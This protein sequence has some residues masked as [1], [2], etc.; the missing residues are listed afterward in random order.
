[1]IASK[2]KKCDEIRIIAP[3]RSINM[4]WVKS[5]VKPAKE[6]LE[7]MGFKVSFGKNVEQIDE[8]NY[9]NLNQIGQS[10]VKNDTNSATGFE[11]DIGGIL[12]F[13]KFILTAGATTINFQSFNWTGGLGVAF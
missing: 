9:D 1:M 6:K 2:L 5:L 11:L 3:D 12:R 13:N 8:F 10:Y 4:T 7:S